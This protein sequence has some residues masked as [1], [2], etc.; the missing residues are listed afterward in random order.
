MLGKGSR[1]VHLLG[2]VLRSHTDPI[3]WPKR[4]LGLRHFLLG[5]WD[6]RAGQDPAPEEGP[7][8]RP[9]WL[10]PPQQGRLVHRWHAERG[11]SVDRAAR[12]RTRQAE[13][14]APTGPSPGLLCG[15][16]SCC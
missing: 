1:Q 10:R 2:Q 14:P 8:G 11:G 15:L 9:H 7:P 3:L 16:V 12:P 5:E 4:G 6:L 13:G